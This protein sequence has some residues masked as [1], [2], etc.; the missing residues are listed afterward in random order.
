[1]NENEAAYYEGYE[2]GRQSL[3]DELEEKFGLT[4]SELFETL[5]NKPKEVFV[6][7]E[8]DRGLGE[9]ILGVYST[10]EKAEDAMGNRNNCYVDVNVC[11]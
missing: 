3:V 4:L 8:E 7:V 11:D 9:T 6:L 10:R 1:M 5:A 2:N